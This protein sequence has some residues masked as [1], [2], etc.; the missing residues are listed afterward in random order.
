MRGY[1][2]W[3][4]GVGHGGFTFTLLLILVTWG[5]LAALAF[6]VFF[7]RSE[8]LDFGHHHLQGPSGRELGRLARRLARGDITRDEYFAALDERW[9]ARGHP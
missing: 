3:N 6:T 9:R 5:G 4:P 8:R 7:H 2:Y 1:G